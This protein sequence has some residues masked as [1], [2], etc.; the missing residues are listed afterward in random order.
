MLLYILDPI[1]FDR[2]AVVEEYESCI[3][4][5]RFIEAGDFTLVMAQGDTH[6]HLIRGGT[7]LEN[8]DSDY[9]MIVEG[10]EAEDGS[11][12]ITGRT[13]E[14]FFS[15][16]S[17][18][19]KDAMGE[20]PHS[21]F[22]T[23]GTPGDV[24]SYFVWLLQDSFAAPVFPGFLISTTVLSG[25]D[26]AEVDGKVND[27]EWGYDVLV[28]MAKE[29]NVDMY[30]KRVEDTTS[31]LN[32]PGTYKFAFGSR[33]PVDHSKTNP[34][35]GG[36]PEL[37]VRFSPEDDNLIGVREAYDMTSDVSAIVVHV[38]EHF[39]SASSIGYSLGPVLYGYKPSAGANAVLT[40]LA[41]LDKPPLE[42]R[43]QEADSERLTVDYLRAQI[44]R[45]YPSEGP[46]Y[47]SSLTSSQKTD[48]LQAEMERLA[49]AAFE[50]AKKRRGH[51][52]DGEVVANSFKYQH[53]FKL[54]DKV[55]VSSNLTANIPYSVNEKIVSEFI[56][57]LDDSGYRAYPTLAPPTLPARYSESSY[58]IDYPHSTYQ[59]HTFSINGTLP[60]SLGVLAPH[61]VKVKSGQTKQLVSISQ[62]GPNVGT[63]TVQFL[64][65][66]TPISSYNLP[67]TLA[68]GDTITVDVSG[69]SSDAKDV[70]GHFTIRVTNKEVKKGKR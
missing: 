54:G 34:T 30:V 70:S 59:D 47:W 49:A 60:A 39:T 55:D 24:L 13:V 25:A 7:V 64:L 48:L 56:R 15:Q 32:G 58:E 57:S 16:I 31:E 3:W 26:G 28:R 37:Q 29:F 35:S 18:S 45:Y 9:P 10:I 14:T 17:L 46:D 38:P 50:N 21:W 5:E 43:L 11:L 62:T 8:E 4:T 2:Y 22:Q 65:N 33:A 53:D 27:R 61:K 40:S 19:P 44:W 12:T 67:L 1:T 52:I 41:D 6:A 68:D 23:N 66:G 51:I 42:I 69:H 20:N 63:C 36:D